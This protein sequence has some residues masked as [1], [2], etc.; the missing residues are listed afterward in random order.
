MT[1]MR[2]LAAPAFG[3]GV[4]TRLLAWP[5]GVTRHDVARRAWQTVLA[6]L[7]GGPGPVIGQ[8]IATTTAGCPRIG[9]RTAD[10]HVL[11]ASY[12][13]WPAD[14]PRRSDEAGHGVVLVAWRHA[15]AGGGPWAIDVAP[16]WRPP[17]GRAL[18]ALY[19][20]V[21]E[22]ARDDDTTFGSAWAVLEAKA[23]LKGGLRECP[24]DVARATRVWHAREGMW[25]CAMAEW[26]EPEP[27]RS[28]AGPP[29]P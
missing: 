1:A 14:A 21:G 8:D 27:R 10:G 6:T 17:E 9:W 4:E 13:V 26:T 2:L 20:G 23:K 12:A 19:G 18:L 11:R 22:S 5:P 29:N 15:C 16:A 28:G 3:T 24:Y 25:C 7:P